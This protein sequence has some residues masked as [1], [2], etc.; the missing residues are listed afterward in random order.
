MIK[1]AIVSPLLVLLAS[2]ITFKFESMHNMHTS[3]RTILA[4]V[5]IV[6]SYSNGVGE[7]KDHVEERNPGSSLNT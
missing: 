7:G 1:N 5:C 2:S 4:T 3:A 6:G